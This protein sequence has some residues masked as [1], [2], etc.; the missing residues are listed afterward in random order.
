MDRRISADG[1]MKRPGFG[2]GLALAFAYAAAA[3]LVFKMMTRTG[4][5]S[6]TTGQARLEIEWQYDEEIAA[7]IIP[8]LVAAAAAAFPA[9]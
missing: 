5:R 7:R 8:V 2:G 4:T 9:R 1:A 6:G 3:T